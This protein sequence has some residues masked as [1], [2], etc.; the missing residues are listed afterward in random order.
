M[1]W[2]LETDDAIA[3]LVGACSGAVPLG[4]AI[5]LL[6]AGIGADADEV[7]RAVLPVVRDL[8]SRGFLEVAR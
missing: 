2:E 7:I 5:A 6:A 4:V 1:R 3:S 8:V